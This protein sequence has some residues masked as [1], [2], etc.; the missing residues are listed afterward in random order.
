MNFDTRRNDDE[1]ETHGQPGDSVNSADQ[2]R[3]LTVVFM[4]FLIF[5]RGPRAAFR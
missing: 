3:L 4:M 5:G 1:L 2:A